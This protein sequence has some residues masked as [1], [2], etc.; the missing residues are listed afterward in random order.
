MLDFDKSLMGM[1]VCHGRWLNSTLVFL[2][3]TLGAVG[4]N[5]NVVVSRSSRES[6]YEHNKSFFAAESGC[7]TRASVSQ[8][9]SSY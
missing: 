2:V 1:W 4:S 3:V 5:T 7:S 8:L 9:V 6:P